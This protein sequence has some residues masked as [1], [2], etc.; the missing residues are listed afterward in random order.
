MNINARG[1]LLSVAL[2]AAAGAGTLAAPATADDIVLA[3]S[4]PGNG[5]IV[6]RMPS[7]VRLTFSIKPSGETV[8]VTSPDG[9]NH[10][11]STRVSGRTVVVSCRG[12]EKGRYKVT[13]KV[14]SPD[15]DAKR[16]AISFRVR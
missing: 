15:G 16:G 12:G 6:R 3:S 11:R 1:G 8:K 5:A 4:T 2:A 13:Y 14:F 9:D 10:A 7:T